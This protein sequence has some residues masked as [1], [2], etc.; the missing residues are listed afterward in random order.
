MII[1]SHRGFWKYDSEKNGLVAFKHSF[2]E[3]FG[4]ETDIRDFNGKLVISHDIATEESLSVEE[5]FETYNSLGSK[6]LLALNIK[7]DGLHS[8]LSI[9]L[10]KYSINNYFVFDMTVPEQ[11]Q[12]IKQNLKT[13][14][15]QSEYEKVPVLYEG[16][17]GVWID[18]FDSDWITEDIIQGHLDN[19]KLVGIVSPEL[20][21][22]DYIPFWN[23]L[24]NMNIIHN[25]NIILCT[26]KPAEARRFFHGKD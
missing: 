12:Y 6:E 16:S 10:K 26:D 22:R 15:R 14:T 23:S 5:F 21:K 25:D 24:K 17:C 13:F 9:I 19:E 2:A 18:S 8:Q 7:A 4:T 3:G 11:I 20:H 1:I